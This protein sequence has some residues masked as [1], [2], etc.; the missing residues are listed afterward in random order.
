MRCC[1]DASEYTGVPDSEP[2]ERALDVPAIIRA[3]DALYARG[4]EREAQDYLER[5]LD[6]AREAGDWRAELS[7][8]SELLGQYRRSMDAQK[9]LAAVESALALIRDH[10]L[11]R[12]VSGATVLLNA[13]TTL[14]FS[15]TW[16]SPTPRWGR[17]GR[18][19]GCSSPR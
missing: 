10:R 1:F 5:R 7:L 14:G 17:R 6:E 4:R 3:L 15:T 16:P 8:T 9:G 12:T 2:C 11:G 13:A 19:R 18:P